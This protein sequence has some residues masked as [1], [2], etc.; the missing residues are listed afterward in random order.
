LSALAFLAHWIV[1]ASTSA[2]PV[3]NPNPNDRPKITTAPQRADKVTTKDSFGERPIAFRTMV[4]GSI[5]SDCAKTESLCRSTHLAIY[6]KRATWPCNV[7]VRS[8]TG[9]LR[10]L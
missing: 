8:K 3:A 2:G 9:F 1:A 10:P 4:Y 5:C 7:G 6:F